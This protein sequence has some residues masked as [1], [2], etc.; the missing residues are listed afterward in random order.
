M[1][2]SRLKLIATYGQPR[3]RDRVRVVSLS[4]RGEPLIRVQWKEG[5]RRKSQSFPDTRKG[6]AE[7]KAYAEGVSDRLAAKA[8]TF[9]TSPISVRELFER[10]ITAKV[11]EWR[12]RTLQNKKYRWQKFELFVN[13]HT[14]AHLVTREHLDEFKRALMKNG[15]AVNQVAHHITNATTVFR[16]G[17][18]RDLIPPTKLVN[19]QVKF[20]RDALRQTVKMA[21]YSPD[22]RR[23]IM[24][25]LDPRQPNYWRAAVLTTLFAFCGPR[26]N[27]ALHLEWAD[28]TLDEPVLEGDGAVTFAG[29]I[30]WNPE[31]DKMGS[32]RVQPLPSPVAEALWVAYGWAIAA[33]YKGRYVFFSARTKVREADRPYGFQAYTRALHEAER[34]ADVTV[35]KYRA[36]HGMRRGIAKDVYELTGSEHKAAEW[37]GDKSV[38]VVKDSY[39]LEREDSQRALAQLVGGKMQPVATNGEKDAT[40]DE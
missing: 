14:P 11:D 21:E 1:N 38:R 35:I 12:P 39:L 29:K 31:L 27:A 26:E 36:A 3:R 17:V 25:A 22:E 40:D 30:R 7:A 24:A 9:E 34:R 23:R 20:S 37:L 2:R 10:Y 8:T 32:D 28:V 15:H 6:Q 16:W 33:G 19:Y 13:R 4:V 18:D 5:D